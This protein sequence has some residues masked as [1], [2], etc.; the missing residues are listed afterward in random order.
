MVKIP[1]TAEGR[2][3][4]QVDARS[5]VPY[6]IPAARRPPETCVSDQRKR[7]QRFV[8]LTDVEEGHKKPEPDGSPFHGE[9]FGQIDWR[10]DEC[11]AIAHPDDE[12]TNDKHG[13]V[14]GRCL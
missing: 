3:Q 5:A 12:A 13:D 2:R 9:S 1:C 6:V 4:D 8:L 10:A 11:H 7:P 14:L